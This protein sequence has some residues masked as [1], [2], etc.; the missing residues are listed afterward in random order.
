MKSA[1]KGKIKGHKCIRMCNT[2]VEMKYHMKNEDCSKKN[3]WTPPLRGTLKINVDAHLSSDGH[4][5]VGLILRRSNR[6]VVGAA[7][8]AH[9]RSEDIL[10]GEA[11]GLNDALDWIEKIGASQVTFELDS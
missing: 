1:H 7:T 6:S 8:Q 10:L 11:L 4:W 3:S 5:F 9:T 2:K